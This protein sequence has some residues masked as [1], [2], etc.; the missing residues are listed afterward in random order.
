M[1]TLPIADCQLPIGVTGEGNWQLE[2]KLWKQS[3]TEPGALATAFKLRFP[4]PAT[5]GFVVF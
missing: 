3:I 4:F 5:L 2:I 1:K